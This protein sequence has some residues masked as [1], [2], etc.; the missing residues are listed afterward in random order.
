MKVKSRKAKGKNLSVSLCLCGVILFFTTSASAQWIK[1][2]VD[3]TASF[4]GLSVVN[5]K[6]I[7]ASGSGGTVIKTTD[8][9]KTWKVMTVPRAE[10]LYFRDVEAFDANTA[11]VLSIGNGESSRIYK[12]SDGGTTWR[13]QFTNTNAKAFF[14]AIACWDR[15]N[16]IA[17]S[18]PVD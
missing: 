7:W 9:G 13:L 4:R 2:T 10:K 11:Y 15:R 3:T 12:T 6:V 16:C 14:D 18:D 17:M 1:Q 8:S 5:E